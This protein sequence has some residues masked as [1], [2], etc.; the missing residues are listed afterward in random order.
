MI[1]KPLTLALCLATIA[2]AAAASDQA[3]S[4]FFTAEQLRRIDAAAPPPA[5]D[6]PSPDLIHLGAVLY[7]GPDNWALWLQGERWTPETDRP[8]LHILAVTP[9]QVRLNLT[10]LD[11]GPAL[12]ITLRPHQSYNR[13]TQTISEGRL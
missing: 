8:D 11:D 7:Y 10:P 6:A 13:V 4:P 9:E 2:A 1:A 12:D 3:A 5:P